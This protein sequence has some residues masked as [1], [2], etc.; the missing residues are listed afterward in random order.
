MRSACLSLNGPYF[1]TP[2]PHVASC[3]HTGP[4]SSNLLVL[5][6]TAL[7]R[8]YNDVFAYLSVLWL[9]HKLPEGWTFACLV[10]LEQL[11]ATP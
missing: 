3:C 1:M 7:R 2:L 4:R 10:H 8:N 11:L 6:F 9:E 5:L